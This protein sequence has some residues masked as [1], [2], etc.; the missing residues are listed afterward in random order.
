MKEIV[1]ELAPEVGVERGCETLAYPRSSYYRQRLRPGEYN[2]FGKK[3]GAGCGG[4]AV[5]SGYHIFMEW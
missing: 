5:E 1:A 4:T 3:W 2:W